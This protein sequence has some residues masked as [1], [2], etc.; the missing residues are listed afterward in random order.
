MSGMR[1]IIGAIAALGMSSAAVAQTA[2][3]AFECDLP[4]GDAMGSMGSLTVTNQSSASESIIAGPKSI[5]EFDPGALQ[6]FGQA[7]TKL[8]LE[9]VEPPKSFPEGDLTVSYR[10]TF[11]RSDAMDAALQSAIGYLDCESSVGWCT[12]A[13]P[14]L[15]ENG[16][17]YFFRENAQELLV[18]CRYQTSLAE[19]EEY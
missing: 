12:G 15:R 14:L 8:S 10:A 11:A 13:P 18:I 9:L 16:Q 6:V 7:P 1:L 3:Q 4:Y 2:Q 17:I 5:V 19:L